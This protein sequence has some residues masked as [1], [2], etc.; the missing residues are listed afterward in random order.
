[1]GH[2]ML[3]YCVLS[4]VA[5]GFVMAGDA[6]AALVYWTSRFDQSVSVGDTDTLGISTIF[7]T[8]TLDPWG[9]ALDVSN[10]HI[11]FTD[12]KD[13]NDSNSAVRRVDTDGT[14][15][16]TLSS[17]NSAVR[18]IELDLTGGKMYWSAEAGLSGGDGDAIYRA[19]LDGTGRQTLA[20]SLWNPRAMSLDLDA[21]KVYYDTFVLATFTRSILRSNLDGTSVETVLT[22]ESSAI[23]GMDID[24][25]NNKLYWGTADSRLVR[26]SN[27]DGTGVETILS[28]LSFDVLD[29]KVDPLAGYVYVAGDNLAG[30]PGGA[31]LRANLDGSNVATLFSG[32]KATNIFVVNNSTAVPE[33]SSLALLCFGTMTGLVGH[34]RR[35]RSGTSQP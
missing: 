12:G 13:F 21:G 34:L 18:Q 2:H 30:N 27:L 24:P 35:R 4:I 16:V 20:S 11:Y 8:G 17:S 31:I 23:W 1:M 19:N 9:I 29:V 14:N 32:V 6:H 25:V 33:P 26:R 28:G 15:F 10:E 3:R 22:G 7:T 5:S